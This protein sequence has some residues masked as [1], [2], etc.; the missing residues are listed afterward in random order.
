[1]EVKY[2]FA[3]KNM[4][5]ILLMNGMGEDPRA[6]FKSC[7]LIVIFKE[8][9]NFLFT[10]MYVCSWVGVY[11]CVYWNTF[12]KM[13][14]QR[15]KNSCVELVLSFRLFIDTQDETQVPRLTGQ[16]PLSSMPSHQPMLVIS[17]AEDT[18]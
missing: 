9:L 13:H 1:M 12:A 10:I 11:M 16:V 7:L 5:M 3:K 18:P 8:V 15:S 6:L 17:C 4:I 2:P 14:M